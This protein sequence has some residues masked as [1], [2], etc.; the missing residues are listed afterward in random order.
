[1]AASPPLNPRHQLVLIGITLKTWRA[2]PA[3]GCIKQKPPNFGRLM[4][5]FAR[6]T[7]SFPF[8]RDECCVIRAGSIMSLERSSLDNV[9]LSTSFVTGCS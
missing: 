5:C 1:M 2:V 8:K 3:C 9:Y 4:Y 7:G 6:G